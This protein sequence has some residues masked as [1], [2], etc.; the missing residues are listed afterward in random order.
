MPIVMLL[1]RM[2]SSPIVP[3]GTSWLSL[4]MTQT[5]TPILGLPAEPRVN[6]TPGW[7]IPQYP[8]HSVIPINWESGIEQT[9]S[10]SSYRS[11]VTKSPTHSI[12]RI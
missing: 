10:H 1:E 5:S 4:S 2:Q 12:E 9:L 7:G 11:G 8:S 6:V 3:V